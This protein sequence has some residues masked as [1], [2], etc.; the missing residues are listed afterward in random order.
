[1]AFIL[2]GASG[3]MRGGTRVKEVQDLQEELWDDEHGR[4]VRRVV[5]RIGGQLRP[6]SHAC[7][8]RLDGPHER[9]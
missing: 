1:M 5:E 3:D 8:S 9:V 7:V 2:I 4:N 6:S